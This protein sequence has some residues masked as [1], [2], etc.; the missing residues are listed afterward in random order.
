MVCGEK[1][2]VPHRRPRSVMSFEFEYLDEFEVKFETNLGYESGGSGEIWRV[3]LMKKPEIKNISLYCPFM[4]NISGYEVICVLNEIL[5]LGAGLGAGQVVA[6]EPVAA[7]AGLVQGGL[8]LCLLS[9][10]FMLPDQVLLSFHIHCYP[11]SISHS[12]CCV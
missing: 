9:S 1:K 6:V 8:Q 2:F 12:Q 4:V 7:A 10:H 3:L 11:V 5:L